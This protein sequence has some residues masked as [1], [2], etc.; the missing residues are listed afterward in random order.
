MK[1]DASFVYLDIRLK[2]Y[3]GARH[4]LGAAYIRAF[5]GQHGIRCEQYLAPPT[6]RLDDM[7][8][9][10]AEH[11]PALVGFT[12]FDRNF[13]LTRLLAQKV[14]ERLP[15]ALIVAGGPTATF[16]Y[17]LLLRRSPAFDACVRHHGEEVSLSLIERVCSD[18]SRSLRDVPQL[19][20]RVNGDVILTDSSSGERN[21]P[22]NGALDRFPSPYLTG[23]IKPELG[24]QVGLT[25]SRG[26]PFRCSYC[27]FSAM[28]TRLVEY[29]S[30]ERIVSELTEIDH[31]LAGRRLP[32]RL[33]FFDDVFT[34]NR[35]RTLELCTAIE[36]A[37]LE[38][39]TFWCETRAD[40]VD[41]E[42]LEHLARAGVSEIN[43]GLES[44]D[45]RVLDAIHK[46]RGGR[47][48]HQEFLGQVKR[49]VLE[50][51]A[52]GIA[53]FV[54]LI[55][56]LPEE[57]PE[58]AHRTLDFIESLP[59]EG[60]SHNFLHVEPGTEL[61]R[62]HAQ[63]GISVTEG[64]QS[65]P[66]RTT[67]AYDVHRDV[68]VRQH[69]MSL[70]RMTRSA[71]ALLVAERLSGHVPR[72]RKGEP[73][74][75]VCLS[76]SL[77]TEELADPWWTSAVGP[78]TALTL[79]NEHVS[80][81]DYDAWLA[82]AACFQL[83]V[84]RLDVA[85]PGACGRTLID[86]RP[87]LQAPPEYYLRSITPGEGNEGSVEEDRAVLNIRE[88]ATGR[89]PERAA[90][91]ILR[92]AETDAKT[93]GEVNL[94]LSCRYACRACPATSY[95]AAWIDERGIRPCPPAPPRDLR[96]LENLQEQEEQAQQA[97]MHRRGCSTCEVRQSCPKCLH[98]APLTAVEYC[99][100]QKRGK[101]LPAALVLEIT[102]LLSRSEPI[103]VTSESAVIRVD[104]VLGQESHVN[105]K[106]ETTTPL[107]TARWGDTPI[108]YDAGNGRLW[109]VPEAL[110]LV[111][112][113]AGHEELDR[114]PAV[115]SMCRS[116]ETLGVVRPTE[117]P[118]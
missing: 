102:R 70:E 110:I 63:Y 28:S 72:R 51:R 99:Q 112:E 78:A 94:E 24:P 7:A 46:L 97:E 36:M 55:F 101:M 42:V 59:L 66:Y 113:L 88:L 77:K 32:T 45:D 9:E 35:S 20:L 68:P 104:N 118:A 106:W 11:S 79:I 87:A 82:A 117:V 25:T 3:M 57:T 27:N 5:L 61:W 8:D 115:D 103:H 12:V 56:G 18:Q 13:H 71:H 114:L 116:L 15:R 67:H 108:L 96:P 85:Q 4:H 37:R 31:S 89:E 107:V 30:I 98:T 41:E 29:H 38:N 69:R 86:D 83:P 80:A 6:R 90:D 53:P 60:Y 21:G 62:T 92:R 74:K 23:A 2:D 84:F 40:L 109:E 58:I 105:K 64:P 43:F 47:S 111:L 1:V 16:S 34:V 93:L 44:T 10:L 19:A 33:E 100:I 48:R 91:W 26:C 76:A 54:S 17:D 14:R 50:A 39:L 95:S 52:V 81:G 73:L 22:R 75:C 49:A 65:L